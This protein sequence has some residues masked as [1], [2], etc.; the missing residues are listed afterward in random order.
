MTESIYF[1]STSSNIAVKTNPT[2]T[3][4]NGMVLW[5]AK[6][7]ETFELSTYDWNK[8]L[9]I[10]ATV[11]SLGLFKDRYMTDAEVKAEKKKEEKSVW[12]K[13]KTVMK[14]CERLIRR[15]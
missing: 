10:N 3:F 8:I 12:N 13:I 14:K 15:I 7:G 4:D 2:I 5:L 1:T 11:R 9:Q 6:E